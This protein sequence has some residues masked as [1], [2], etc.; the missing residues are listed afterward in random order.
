MMK[1][2]SIVLA[3]LFI[4]CYSGSEVIANE[5]NDF[6][7]RGKIAAGGIVEVFG[8]R[9]DIEAEAST[10]DE[11]E[12]VAV[13]RGSQEELSRVAVR[14]EESEGRVK[15]C[16][17]YPNLEGI[18]EPRCLESLEWQ[19]NQWNDGRELRL[20]Y[21]N[22]NRQSVRLLDVALQI[23]VRVP[24][25]VQFIART[26]KGDISASYGKVSISRPI[27]LVSLGG[28]VSLEAPMKLNARVRLSGQDIESDFPITVVGHFRGNGL[29]GSIGQGGPKISL[30]GGD[31][32]L[33]QADEHANGD[34]KNFSG[35]W[36]TSY[37]IMTLEQVGDS[38]SGY[39]LMKHLHCSIDGKVGN[40]RLNFKFREP[41]S[42]GEGWFELKSRG[43]RFS[44]MWRDYRGSTWTPWKGRRNPALTTPIP[45]FDIRFTSGKSALAIPFELNNNHIY[46]G[47]SVNGSAP[48]SF[49]L[50]TGGSSPYPKINLRQARS[51][52]MELQNLNMKNGGVGTELP[53][54]Y[55][56]TNAT[57]FSLPGVELSSQPMLAISL[58]KVNGCLALGTKPVD[59]IIGVG[60]FRSFVVEID[61][62]AQLINLYDPLTYKYS[63]KG[64]IL[65][66]EIEPESGLV[67]VRGEV[68]AAGHPPVTARLLVDTGSTTALSLNLQFA[69]ANKIL[70]PADK[71]KASRECGIGGMA[72]GSSF[73]DTLEFLQLGDIELPR[74]STYFHRKIIAQG[75]YDGFLGGGTLRNFKV[76]F[77][78]SHSR[79]I[80]EPNPAAKQ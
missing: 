64:R 65:P 48:L 73:E 43:D 66:L 47:V 46:L 75:Y 28:G 68:K 37:G 55:L 74:I 10:D 21:K 52:G 63:G 79:M 35:R 80:L 72:E 40:G 15:I 59:G 22:G 69:E 29:E 70:P 78:L 57:S 32:L 76:I 44:G 39:Y 54:L 56:V 42:S 19:S 62:A 1:L 53:D 12:V 18:G 17:A 6:K 58:D 5:E 30:S 14:V 4:S 67:F 50:D 34:G 49:I 2:H 45:G 26:L 38:V 23:K 36:E 3:T 24:A 27:D 51:F 8:V 61:Y 33:R 11:L 20:V 13:K 9:G 77:D 41:K 60:F 7:W 31:V 16:A 25:G 71:L